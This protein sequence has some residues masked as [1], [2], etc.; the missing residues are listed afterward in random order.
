MT[1]VSTH[2][3]AV[4]AGEFRLEPATY[5]ELKQTTQ[6]RRRFPVLIAN[7]GRA[8]GPSPMLHETS[9]PRDTPATDLPPTV[10]LVGVPVALTDYEQ[11]LR[12][13]DGTV[14]EGDRGYVCVCNVHTVMA[15]AEDQQLRAALLGSS[16]NVPD[17]QPLVWAMKALGHSIR[18]RVYGPE[19]MARACARAAETGHRFYLY[20]GRDQAALFQLTA[21]L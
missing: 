1:S 17:G 2:R 12:W 8:G 6:P 13:I 5:E 7:A 18:R 10:K 3:I 15:S 11:T 4:S 14:A 20:G 19:L 9:L 21:T 16:I